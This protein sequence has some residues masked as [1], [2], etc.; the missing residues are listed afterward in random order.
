MS[1][2]QRVGV[3][4]ADERISFSGLPHCGVRNSTEE[5]NPRGSSPMPL[6]PLDFS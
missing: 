4:S 3:A 6:G 2:R 5:E 1:F